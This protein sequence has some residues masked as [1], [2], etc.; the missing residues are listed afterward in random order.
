MRNVIAALMFL[1]FPLH[2]ASLHGL[3]VVIN[4]DTVDIL[5][6]NSFI[7]DDPK[8]LLNTKELVLSKLSSRDI[9]DITATLETDR[10]TIEVNPSAVIVRRMVR[11][12]LIGTSG[13]PAPEILLEVEKDGKII[14]WTESVNLE[15]VGPLYE[16]AKE[17]MLE[18]MVR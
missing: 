6:E 16:D 12:Q 13:D 18:S 4:D 7:C 17:R 9:S 2:A 15:K 8:V 5:Y 1:S 3:P 14:G 10:C 11:G